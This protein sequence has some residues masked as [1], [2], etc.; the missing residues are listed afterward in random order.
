M[1]ETFT[2]R[3]FSSSFR[4][5]EKTLFVQGQDASVSKVC[6]LKNESGEIDHVLKSRA[7]LLKLH[8]VNIVGK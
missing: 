1:H 8:D 6:L 3:K 4:R 5:I 2:Q 7:N